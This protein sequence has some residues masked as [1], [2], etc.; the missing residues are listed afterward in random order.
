MVVEIHIPNKTTDLGHGILHCP[1]P[2]PAIPPRGDRQI[3]GFSFIS[4]E[5]IERGI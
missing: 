2:T 5:D 4:A 3:V 1:D